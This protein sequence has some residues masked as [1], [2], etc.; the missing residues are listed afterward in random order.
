[1]LWSRTAGQQDLR[2]GHIAAACIAL[3]T[4][5]V[6]AALCE[7]DDW[8]EELIGATKAA[9]CQIMFP[10]LVGCIISLAAVL[11]GRPSPSPSPSPSLTLTYRSPELRALWAACAP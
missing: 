9:Y 4:W 11:A 7:D 1:M 10:S 6:T 3:L 5:A 8:L 2:R